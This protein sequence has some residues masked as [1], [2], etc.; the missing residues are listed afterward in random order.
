MDLN[1]E[2]AARL[3]GYTEEHVEK[4]AREGELPSY[5]L[6]GQYRFNAVELHEWAAARRHR[7]SPE[8]HPPGRDALPGLADALARGGIHHGIA[9]ATRED[10]LAAVARLPAIPARVDRALLR[11]L[12]VSREAL[13]STGVGN[14]IAIPHPRD[15]LVVH[16]DEAVLVLCFL[17]QPVDFGA[18]DEKPVHVLF[19]LLAPT[20]R[21]H[22]QLLAKLSWCLHDQDLHSLLARHAP[23]AAVM[24]RIQELERDA[25]R[26]RGEASR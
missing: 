16:V 23:A 21:Q 20:V 25:E 2:A 10:V 19:T 17:A 9:G 15:P 14:G 22:L 6:E 24:K 13:A 1:V 3:L 11:D 4:L 18:V 7:I 26:E 5:H 12:L 8:I